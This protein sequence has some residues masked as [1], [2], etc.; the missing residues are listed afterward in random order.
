MPDKNMKQVTLQIQIDDQTAQG[1]YANMAVV[2]H[3]PSEFILD[4]IFI[5]PGAPAAKVRSRI[6]MSPDHAKRLSAALAEN[7]ARY[8]KQFGEIKVFDQP[9][10]GTTVQ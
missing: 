9:K 5:N 10:P 1:V 8:E 6:I 4:F 3:S 7:I 2:Q